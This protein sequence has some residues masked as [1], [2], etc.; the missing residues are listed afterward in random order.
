MAFDS[1]LNELTVVIFSFQRPKWL[2]KSIN[3]WS[4]YNIELIIIDGSEK[5]LDI[6]SFKNNKNFELKYYH[7]PKPYVERLSFCLKLNL[8]KYV[9]VTCDDEIHLIDGIKES[10]NF[11]NKNIKFIG[12]N[13]KCRCIYQSNFNQIKLFNPYPRFDLIN[14]NQNIKAKNKRILGYFE[15]Y[16]CASYYSV[17]RSEIWKEDLELIC[18]TKISCVYIIEKLIELSNLSKGKIFIHD[19]VS[20]VRNGL[21]SPH[22]GVRRKTI[23]W[24]AKNKKM[25]NEHA[26][27]KKLITKIM[28]SSKLSDSIFEVFLKEKK[29]KNKHYFLFLINDIP[30]LKFFK[31][32]IK[33][34][35]SYLLLRNKII[36]NSSLDEL[37]KDEINIMDSFFL[38]S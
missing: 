14:K 29:I 3:Y 35:L 31:N 34:L 32:I 33:K 38:K 8:R 15:N 6:K 13:G 21:V 7:L 37:S 18:K 20:W 5:I 16:N 1:L 27:T 25:A 26:L 30:F 28:K 23:S 2:I 9:L 17:M 11:L 4:K 10:I 22:S 24:W 36:I 19:K 12:A